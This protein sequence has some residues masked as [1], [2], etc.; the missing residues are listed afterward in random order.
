MPRKRKSL[1][2]KCDVE[3]AERR[4]TCKH[5]KTVI[6]KGETCFVVWDTQFDRNNYSADVA[7]QMIDDAKVALN[8]IEDM[9]REDGRR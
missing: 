8:R 9:L 3:I 5:S 1:I 2:K 4:R 6:A 7:R